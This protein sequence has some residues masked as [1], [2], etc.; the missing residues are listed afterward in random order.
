[1]RRPPAPR[2]HPRGTHARR[3]E[4]QQPPSLL[5]GRHISMSAIA[6]MR[7]L[8]IWHSPE[9]ES[10]LYGIAMALHAHMVQATDRQPSGCALPFHAHAFERFSE[11][12]YPLK[13]DTDKASLEICPTSEA[14]HDFLAE[15]H[16]QLD[17]DV[18]ILVMTLVYVERVLEL[19][20]WPLLPDTWRRMLLAG[21]L[22]AAKVLFD[23]L[24]FNI[25]LTEAF[26]DWNLA[27]IN[28]LELFFCDALQYSFHVRSSTY[29]KFY[30]CLTSLPHVIH[31]R[32]M[33]SSAD[34]AVFDAVAQNVGSR[35]ELLSLNH[36]P[37]AQS[38]S[39][40]GRRARKSR[41][42]KADRL[43]LLSADPNLAAMQRLGSFP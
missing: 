22:A 23:E 1:M 25:D 11:L 37:R 3:G 39:K 12:L 13:S 18:A 20:A 33:V 4:P 30:F 26:P 8:D 16:R 29:A 19:N 40:H 10:V 15:L 6:K 27:D 7:P 2:N 28:S 34:V 5:A 24:V 43:A 38:P 21:L 17:I 14:V 36:D 9:V 42:G 31:R 35:I 41:S 32:S